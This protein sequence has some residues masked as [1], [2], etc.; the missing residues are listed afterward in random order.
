[1]RSGRLLVATLVLLVTGKASASTDI[2]GLF[3]ARS[4]AMG[5][6]GAGYLDNPAAIPTNPSLLDQ[7]GKLSISLNGFYIRSSPEAPYMV[8]HPDGAGGY[9]RNYE[10]I[11]SEA[12]DAV[13]PFIGAAYRL[14]ERLVL[15]IAL[16]PLVGQGTSAKYR[17]SPEALPGLQISNEAYAALVET[18][19]ALSVKILDN[20]S[21]AAMWRVTYMLQ[22]V[23]TSVPGGPP[24][25]VLRDTMGNPIYGDID[26]SGFNFTGFQLGVFWKPIPALGLGLS[27]RNKIVVE[28]EGHT[29]VNGLVAGG[30]SMRFDTIQE[31]ANPHQIRAGVAWSPLLDKLMFAA[32]FKYNMY[33]EA[34]KTTKN[35]MT[36]NGTTMTRV[37]PTYWHDSIS[38]HLGGEYK[39][40]DSFAVRLG[41]ILVTSATNETYAQA[42]MAPVG[43][44]HAFLGGVGLKV[45]DQLN[46][47]LAAGYVVLAGRIDTATPYNA[48]IGIYRA[49]GPEASLSATFHL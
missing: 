25:G 6:T 30:P 49:A 27:F 45:L 2:N 17:P 20:L 4:H 21:V 28:G 37:V 12:T 11:R 32:D 13:L 31:F 33:A 44:S 42:F 9:Y 43:I 7:I 29:V 18:G 46:V 24:A 22:S 10:S 39:V 34:W 14:Q 1:M 26:V 40:L 36:M 15:G 41:Y 16:Y 19:T 38:V 3:D 35:I 5:G 8:V 48:G 47:D 23:K